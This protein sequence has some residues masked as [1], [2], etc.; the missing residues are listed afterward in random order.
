MNGNDIVTVGL[1]AACGVAVSIRATAQDAQTL[2]RIQHSLEENEQ[3]R[4]GSG[5]DLTLGENARVL[6][7]AFSTFSVLTTEDD[8]G[9]THSLRQTDTKLWT[10][11]SMAGHEVYARA[12]FRYQNFSS[13]DSF[14]GKGDGLT[15]PIADRYW[16]KFDYRDAHRFSTGETSDVDGWIQAGRQ[17]VTWASG[18]PLSKDLYSVRG[19]GEV[20]G[21][22]LN[23]LAGRTPPRSTVDF[24][25]SRPDYTGDVDRAFL[26][27]QLSYDRGEVVQPYAYVL[28]QD[29]KNNQDLATYTINFIPYVTRFL[30]DSTYFGLG[31]RGQLSGEVS[32]RLEAIREVGRSVSTPIGANG[33]PTTQTEDAI[34]AWAGQL[35]VSYAPRW[36]H[37]NGVLME[38][39]LLTASGDSDRGQSSQTFGG[40]RPG[41]RDRGFNAFGFADTGLAL[42]PDL[43]NLLCLRVGASALPY[44][45]RGF[46]EKMR[47]GVNGYVLDKLSHDAPISVATTNDR[48]VGFE[49]DFFVDWQLTSDVSIEARYGIFLPGDAIPSAQDDVRQFL[50]MG[51]SYAF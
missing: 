20:A 14:D 1:L 45:H 8:D 34:D 30:Y 28:N 35:R 40:N 41:T 9:H 12:R 49:S 16:Y 23:G 7:G 15:D 37:D 46:F 25:A 38:S 51:L 36:G 42:A 2:E 21:F 44:P 22:S 11:F 31:S 19:G 6:F 33:F 47:A 26:G 18:I 48:F 27:L 5:A 43:S 13:G 4:Y 32:Y 10:D 3:L 39:E 29:D 50:Y 17:Q 24:D